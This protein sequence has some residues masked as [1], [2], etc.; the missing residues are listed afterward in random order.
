MQSIGPDVGIR[1]DHTALVLV[2]RRGDR[3][4]VLLV[5]QQLRTGYDAV[6]DRV[7]A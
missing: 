2:E 1:A 4:E 5:E 6:V 7:A 3:I